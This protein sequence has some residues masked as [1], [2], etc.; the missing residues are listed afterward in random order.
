M[1]ADISN[2]TL[3]GV[4][5]TE[6]EPTHAKVVPRLHHPT[7]EP[8]T[9]WTCTKRAPQSTITK[10]AANAAYQMLILALFGDSVCT[11]DVLSQQPNDFPIH[12]FAHAVID[13]DTGEA[14]EYCDLSTKPK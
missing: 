12:P 11:N 7:P 1:L 5:V 13:P 14:M 10:A 8:I 3:P 6:T 2:G 4:G 9:M